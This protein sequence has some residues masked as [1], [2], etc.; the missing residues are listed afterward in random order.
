MVE[1]QN[2]TDEK[3]EKKEEIKEE[4]PV[5]EKKEAPKEA[6]KEEPKVVEKAKK[7]VKIPAKFKDLVKQIEELSIMDLAELVKILEE[8]FGVSPMAAPIAVGPAAA[9]E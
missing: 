7:E 3:E 9:G 2:K 1:E 5:E 6:P 4:K 8:K